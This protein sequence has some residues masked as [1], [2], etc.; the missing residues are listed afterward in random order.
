[1]SSGQGCPAGDRRRTIWVTGGG[2]REPIDAVRYVGNRSTGRLATAIVQE[3]SRR[4]HTVRAILASSIST[5]LPNTV[6]HVKFETA[7][8]LMAALTSDTTSPDVLIHAAAVADYVPVPRSGKTPSGQGSWTLEMQPSPKVVDAF[9]Q[10]H[11]ATDILLFKL[12]TE[13]SM[14]DLKVRA[15]RAAGRVGAR[16]VFANLLE[17]T[18]EEHAG[19]LLWAGSERQDRVAARPAIARVLLDAIESAVD[20][21]MEQEGA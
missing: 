2:T 14:E 18:G 4:Q 11:P 3:A 15:L 16:W 6:E 20:G 9:R 8:E 13:I 21:A 12:E 10:R 17:Q 5:E 1:M 19:V 7:I